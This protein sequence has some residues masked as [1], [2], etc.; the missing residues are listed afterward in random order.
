MQKNDLLQKENDMVRILK[1]K[2]EMI[3]VIDCV[4]RT[5]PFWMA[6]SELDGYTRCT[7]TE[8][9][10]I[11]QTT[12]L[13][14]DSLNA[15]SKRVMHERYTLIAGI[16]PF[17]SDNEQRNAMM[18]RISAENQVS[19]QTLRKYLCLYLVFQ[20][21]AIL[22]PIQNAKQKPLSQ[23]EKNIRWAL[24][25]FYYTKNKNSLTTAYTMM[26][27]EK[28]C[29]DVGNL[30]PNHPTIY[31]F[32][33]FYRKYKKLQTHYISRD[34]IKNY[35][36]NNRPLLGDGIREFAPNI[37][38]AMLDSTI[39][40]IYL[41]NE[42]GNLIGRP[43]LTACVDAY[44]GL[45]C[46]YTLTW[47]GGMYSLRRLLINVISDKVEHCK[48]FGITISQEDWNCVQLPAV[49]VTDKGTEYKSENFEQLTELGIKIINLPS[50]R[51]ELKGAVEKFFDLVQTSYKKHLKG[52]GVIEMDYQERGAHDYRK[53]AN[54][55]LNEF[56][57]ILL[58]CILYYNT[59]RIIENF[60]YT[61]DMIAQNIQPHASDIWNYGLK[62]E[63]ANLIGVSEEM[64]MQTLLPRTTGKFQRN[65][66]VV[67]KLRY[68]HDGYTECYLQGGEVTVAYNPNDVS[69]VWLLENSNYVPF[70]L[71]ETRF[72]GQE[73]SEVYATKSEQRQ[74][75]KKAS[76][77][78]LQAQIN[79]AEHIATIVENAA[80]FDDVNLKSVRT[81]RSKERIR[82]HVDMKGGGINV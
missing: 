15:K 38:V 4:H 50:Y 77:A 59:E 32:K 9:L 72:K 30:L 41:I 25:K 39:C 53:D 54:L 49:L 79:L 67:N 19:K 29:D 20:N 24:N 3:F 12:I 44:S 82:T 66:L 78:N 34:G 75:V 61:A 5:M 26:L 76:E 71:I 31:Q 69:M 37:G 58:H 47:E 28:Y 23:D 27:K 73:L 1:V 81:T 60:P 21:M 80:S 2:D 52:K 35:Q 8:L 65:G 62:Q 68:K 70:I 22:A 55:T 16:L 40:D 17:I 42:S 56:E 64:L 63:G 10:D 14:I 46:G 36:R 51:P 13:D 43:I 18:E 6:V 74:L 57:K 33:Y 48:R 7:E 11:T 45:C